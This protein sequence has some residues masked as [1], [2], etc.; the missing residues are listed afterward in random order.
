M[1]T[2]LT[3]PEQVTQ[4]IKRTEWCVTYVNWHEH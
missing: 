4:Q 3:P 2:T 1:T